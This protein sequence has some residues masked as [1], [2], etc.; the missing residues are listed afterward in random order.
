MKAEAR[1]NS[2]SEITNKNK[3]YHFVNMSKIVKI[4]PYKF[5]KVAESLFNALINSDD[6]K[7]AKIMNIISNQDDETHI[8]IAKKYLVLVNPNNYYLEGCDLYERINKVE[9]C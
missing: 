8:A 1:L 3:S 7:H 5:D 6:L 2:Q 4:A 9:I